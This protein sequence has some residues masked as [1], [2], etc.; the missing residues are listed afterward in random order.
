MLENEPPMLPEPTQMQSEQFWKNVFPWFSRFRFPNHFRKSRIPV[1]PQGKSLGGK[2]S[3]IDPLH[4]RCSSLLVKSIGFYKRNPTF[5]SRPSFLRTSVWGQFKKVFVC[6]PTPRPQM[7]LE[8]H[9]Y[10]KIVFFAYFQP[11]LVANFCSTPV[12]PFSTKICLGISLSIPGCIPDPPRASGTPNL[13]E[14]KK[15]SENSEAQ[16]GAN[17]VFG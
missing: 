10:W 12:G 16:A 7:L 6:S 2:G 9:Y 11:G 13:K 5:S 15:K 1:A 17:P 14:N 8:N 4:V 3:Y